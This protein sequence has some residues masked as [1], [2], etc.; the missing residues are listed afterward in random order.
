MISS[1]FSAL[2]RVSNIIETVSNSPMVSFVSAFIASTAIEEKFP[3]GLDP[4]T[5]EPDAESFQ[6]WFEHDP[7]RMVESEQYADALRNLDE[8]YLDAGERDEFGLQWGLRRFVKRLQ[9]A[10]ID[11]HVEYFNGGHFDMDARYEI[12]LPKIL[13]PIAQSS[14]PTGS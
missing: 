12:S 11:H 14:K 5:G 7:V 3:D 2:K 6:R 9:A 10:D 1:A 13:R 4:E 8:L